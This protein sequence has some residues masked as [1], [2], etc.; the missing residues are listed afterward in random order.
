[1]SP[2]RLR[3][4]LHGRKRDPRH[5]DV[6][7]REVNNAAERRAQQILSQQTIASIRTQGV[8]HVAVTDETLQIWQ[9]RMERLDQWRLRMLHSARS[10][11]EQTKLELAMVDITDIVGSMKDDIVGKI[12]GLSMLLWVEWPRSPPSS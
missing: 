7:V 11:E 8:T 3:N 6:S 5:E 12:E 10:Q 2:S 1:M 9:E 4:W